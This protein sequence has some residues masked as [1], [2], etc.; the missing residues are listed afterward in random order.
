MARISPVPRLQF[1]DDNGDPLVGGKLYTY[2]AG[3]VTPLATYTDAG[4]GTEHTNPIILDSRGEVSLWLGSSLYDFVIHNADDELI[5]TADDIS[6][7]ATV[8]DLTAANITFSVTN[9]PSGTV[10]NALDGLIFE[11]TAE[12]IAAGVTPTNYYY[13]PGNVKRYGASGNGSDA[14]SAFQ[15]A[16]SIITTTSGGTVITVPRGD[17]LITDWD[18]SGK[19]GIFLICDS[20]TAYAVIKITGKITC[21]N[22]TGLSMTNVMMVGN[23]FSF[24]TRVTSGVPTAGNYCFD[25]IDNCAEWNISNC[26]FYGFDQVFRPNSG[27]SNGAYIIDI[28]SNYFGWNN[29]SISGDGL[30]HWSVVDNTFSE[31]Y[32]ANIYI[33]SGQEITIRGNKHE[34]SSHDLSICNYYLTKASLSATKSIIA[35]NTFHQF[36]GIVIDK[37]LGVIVHDNE[38]YLQKSGSG[39]EVKGGSESIILHDNDLPGWDGAAARQYGIYVVNN[40]VDVKIHDNIL[41]DW[42]V[43]LYVD[44]DY[45]IVA[46]NNRL[47]GTVYSA[48]VTGCGT[49]GRVV[50][51]N[52]VCTGNIISVAN[53]NY[54]TEDRNQFLSGTADNNDGY[55]DRQYAEGTWTPSPSGLTVVGAP[56]YTGYFIKNGK[57][58]TIYLEISSTTST[59][60][61]AGTTYFSGLPYTSTHDGNCMATT[62]GVTGWGGAYNWST[63]LYSYLDS[64]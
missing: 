1:F 2:A 12:E 58:I 37:C 6:S 4:G 56:T 33:T 42:Q 39:I 17:Y 36:Y 40:C 41:K 21:D 23:N 13:A 27:A 44:S 7:Q 53:T 43:P 55:M 50:L 14:T 54:W 64:G 59:A 31:D 10:Q 25:M 52:N 3:T 51:R 22:T 35:D 28:K 30:L 9:G 34:N 60:S 47:S 20:K 8:A 63:G 19:K 49:N 48:Q 29:R 18:L 26:H 62:T 15:Q 57:Q 11:R 46:H 16:A 45:S 61:T 24:S 5:Y 32:E 38:S